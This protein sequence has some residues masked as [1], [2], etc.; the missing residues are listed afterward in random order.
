MKD[1]ICSSM[2]D[3]GGSGVGKSLEVNLDKVDR[4]PL[5]ISIIYGGTYTLYY[6]MKMMFSVPAETREYT[7]YYFQGR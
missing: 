2:T 3:A 4:G 5:M 6:S 1:Q 7:V